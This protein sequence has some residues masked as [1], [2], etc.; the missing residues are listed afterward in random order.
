[1]A[2]TVQAPVLMEE[3]EYHPNYNSE[4]GVLASI[5]AYLG[6]ANSKKEGVAYLDTLPKFVDIRASARFNAPGSAPGEG[7]LGNKFQVLS[8]LHPGT[9]QQ[10]LIALQKK[11]GKPQPFRKAD[12]SFLSA[13]FDRGQKHIFFGLP[14]MLITPDAFLP[15]A[16]E[17]EKKPEPVIPLHDPKGKSWSLFYVIPPKFAAQ[18]IIS[19]YIHNH[20]DTTVAKVN[21]RV[22]VLLAEFKAAW[23]IST[24]DPSN[25]KETKAIELFDKCYFPRFPTIFCNQGIFGTFNLIASDYITSQDEK[26]QTA[27]STESKKRT[28]RP[29]VEVSE[30]DDV[31]TIP[32][33]DVNDSN[34][35]SAA[36]KGRKTGVKKQTKQQPATSSRDT[37]EDDG[38]VTESKS[39]PR[40]ATK[41]QATAAKKALTDSVNEKRV[42]AHH[43]AGSLTKNPDAETLEYDLANADFTNLPVPTRE[44][45]VDVDE[46]GDEGTELSV[47]DRIKACAELSPT[48]ERL[49]ELT[50]WTSDKFN[51]VCVSLDD[52]FTGL[53]S[54]EILRKSLGAHLLQSLEK[55]SQKSLQDTNPEWVGNPKMVADKPNT[56]GAG[57]KRTLKLPEDMRLHLGT[58][59]L[60]MQLL[61][62]ENPELQKFLSE[63]P[64]RITK[65]QM[66]AGQAV[67][68]P[69]TS[70]EVP[71]G[72]NMGWYNYMLYQGSSNAEQIL[73]LVVKCIEATYEAF[74]LELEEVLKEIEKKQASVSVALYTARHRQIKLAKHSLRLLE[75]KEKEKAQILLLLEEKEKEK[76]KALHDLTVEHEIKVD[77][78]QQRIA[79]L[80]SENARLSESAKNGIKEKAPVA[81][82]VA[83][84]KP[85]LP[86]PTP[87]LQK[88]PAKPPPVPSQ[89]KTKPSMPI[90]QLQDDPE[91]E[92]IEEETEIPVVPIPTST[93][94]GDYE[95]DNY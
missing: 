83:K 26:A 77:E 42:L 93:A 43:I 70:N 49:S 34:E 63:I 81:A 73:D 1:M 39:Q 21:Q 3:I 30:E 79:Y 4:A 82:A 87:V 80:E 10:D 56:R 48:P 16:K 5:Q 46:G 32:L 17:G 94:S 53:K 62:D 19:L 59:S 31:D 47:L 84:S 57:I 2:T 13:I 33:M 65:P 95:D 6:H 69:M 86:L 38:E 25:D 50:T 9:L 58:Y 75:E 64:E 41:R 45:T 68:V 23:E 91:E 89:G 55:I 24:N 36:P 74:G 67:F 20:P 18:I 14:M 37:V 72:E 92:T 12:L 88:T 71:L 54:P 22:R 27:T 29:T 40:N 15:K 60:L 51:K 28:T 61:Q 85:P 66:P 78:L 11:G 52:I 90:L 76:T 35:F 7:R 44:P 8:T